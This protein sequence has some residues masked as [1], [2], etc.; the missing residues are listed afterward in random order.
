[1]TI[2]VGIDPGVNGAVAVLY[3]NGPVVWDLPTVKDGTRKALDVFAL[4][5]ELATLPSEDVHVFIE[6]VWARA[7]EG[8]AGAFSFGRAY[9]TILGLVAALMLRHDLV[10]PATWCRAMNAPNDKDG[11][12][13]TAARLFPQLAAQMTKKKDHNKADALLIAEYGR[14]HLNGRL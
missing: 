6:K 5:T 7:N 11:R 10:A 3:D 1:M 4:G 12:L 8:R 2:V 14:R 9:G 13:A